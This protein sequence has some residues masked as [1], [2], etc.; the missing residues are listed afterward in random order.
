[1]ARKK[2]SAP[3]RSAKQAASR[4]KATVEKE[5]EE[6]AKAEKVEI[7]DETMDNKEE[8]I[9]DLEVRKRICIYSMISVL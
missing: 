7:E 3:K 6:E 9:K 4:K 8:N 1:M 2:V 5:E